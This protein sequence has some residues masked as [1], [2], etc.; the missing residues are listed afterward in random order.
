MVA[1]TENLLDARFQSQFAAQSAE[2]T[3]QLLHD[4]PHTLQRTTKSLLEYA[5]E[6][7]H[8]LSPLEI[9]R[10]RTRIE[11]RRT[12]QHLDQ[13]PIIQLLGKNLPCRN[14]RLVQGH[15]VVPGNP[16]HQ[17]RKIVPLAR[18]PLDHLLLEILEVVGE[19]QCAARED[20][21]RLTLRYQG[22]VVPTQ[23]EL[24]E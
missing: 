11:H 14:L 6:H 8:E 7:D 19:P 1:V 10:S 23:A 20:D 5:A 9:V 12:Q 24:S 15:R 3:N 22:E 17:P 4:Q 13:Q 18:K 16:T 2:L 21:R